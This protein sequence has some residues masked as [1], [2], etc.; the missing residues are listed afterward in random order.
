MIKINKST[1]IVSVL[2]T[3]TQAPILAQPIDVDGFPLVPDVVLRDPPAAA[4]LMW[5]R[6][7]DSWGYSPLDQAAKQGRL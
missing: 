3:L 7:L 6:T 4:W 1:L 5:R 2:C